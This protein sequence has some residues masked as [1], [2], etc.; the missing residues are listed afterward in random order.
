[1]V[2]LQKA[3]PGMQM[4][5]FGF[6]FYILGYYDESLHNDFRVHVEDRNNIKGKD[7]SIVGK[8]L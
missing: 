5:L 1:V 6:I 4:Y 2:V 8:I 7:N 3:L